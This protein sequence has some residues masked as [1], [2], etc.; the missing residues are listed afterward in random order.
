MEALAAV[1]LGAVL[2]MHAWQ[3]FG[4]SH[5]KT[6]GIVAAAGAIILASL[7]AWQPVA[8]MTKVE[9]GALST[10]IAVW[11]IYAALVAGAGLWGLD[12]RGLGL[13]SIF[14][15][16]VMIG[17]I[18]YCATVVYVL[19]GL[20][21]GVVQA[22]AF[23]ILFCYFAIPM[24]R[25]RLGTAWVLIVVSVVHALLAAVLFLKVPGLV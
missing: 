9:P 25:L 2:F 18:M 21:C 16:V 7:V 17:Q 4:L 11:A 12:A 8:T 13:Y 23:A 20:I 6:T 24:A 5:P 19:A 10:S 14:A 15:A 1:I 3:L 22:V